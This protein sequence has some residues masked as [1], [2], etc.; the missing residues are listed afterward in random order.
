MEHTLGHCACSQLRRTSRA[1]SGLYDQFLEPA[2]ITVTQYAILVN[3]AR[4]EDGIARTSLA[5]LLGMDR[6]TLTRNLRPLERAKLVGSKTDPAD[7][8]S[9][10][11]RLTPT[12]T[13]KLDRAFALWAD[14]QQKFTE[15]FGPTKVDEL[16]DLLVGAAS[17]ARALRKAE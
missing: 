3:I 1:I 13:R 10:I 2:G 7:R 5:T 9:S 12:G 6:T 17:A 8:R 16:R 11:L 15:S 14:V 4:H